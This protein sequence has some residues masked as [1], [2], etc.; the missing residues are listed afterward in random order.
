MR[1]A[2]FS[3]NFYPE[4]SGISDSIL[5]TGEELR[6]RGHDIMYAA[7]WYPRRTYKKTRDAARDKLPALRL[8]SF[9]YPGSPTGQ[10]RIAIPF[11]YS[12]PAMKRFR[13][14]VIHA[15]SPHGAGLEAFFAARALGVPLVGTEHTPVEE[16]ARYA[17]IPGFARAWLA[18][19]RWYYNRCAFVTTPYQGLYDDMRHRGLRAPGRG[20]SNPVP[21]VSSM[22]SDEE[23]HACKTQFGVKGPLVLCSGRLAPEKRVDDVIR[24]FALAQK[25]VPHATLVITG[26]GTSEPGLKKLARQLDV[27]R[28]VRFAGFVNFETLGRLYCTAEAYIIMSTAE[29]QSLSLM[30]AYAS[31]TPAVCADSHGLH[32]YTP[33]DCGFLVAPGDVQGA[34]QK[35]LTL[36]KDDALRARM[37]E[38]GAE[39]VKKFAP[40]KIAAQWEEIYNS[41]LNAKAN[42]PPSRR[43]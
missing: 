5:T 13:P 31:G 9:H 1:I 37:G 32:D 30:Q 23:R 6:R 18:W 17:P 11:G 38:A 28:H 26:H 33:Q 21:F 29:T 3:D 27:E 15:Q 40:D 34:A 7:P 25:E 42:A 36:F 41:V 35:L 16:F 12:I 10:S 2:Y 43:A 24:A 14:D 4:I 8:P 20:E 22:F 39:F 19:E